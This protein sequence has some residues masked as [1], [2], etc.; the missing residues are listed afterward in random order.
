MMRFCKIREVKSPTRANPGDA[1]I[2]FF[3]PTFDE[4]FCKDFDLKNP[5]QKTW[6]N[7]QR[8]SIRVDS[9]ARVLIPSGIKV[10]VPFGFALIAFNKSGVAVK[11]GF[12]VGASVVDHG[13]QGEVHLSLI[14]TS[15]TTAYLSEGEK[16]VQF[17]IMPIVTLSPNEVEEDQLHPI[18]TVRG[19]GGFGSSG[20]S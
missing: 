10:D 17:L 6:I 3:I 15:D 5:D 8:K 2:D 12:D 19:A 16:A 7:D 11:K 1:G 4:A 18:E 9:Q 14:N 20:T 13:Y